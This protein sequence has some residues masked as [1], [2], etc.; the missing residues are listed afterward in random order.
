M[1]EHKLQMLNKLLKTLEAREYVHPTQF[2]WE[3]N[4]VNTIRYYLDIH[5][6]KEVQIFSRNLV[7]LQL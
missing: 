4:I 3:W 6:A 1:A 7:Q 2:Y 5:A